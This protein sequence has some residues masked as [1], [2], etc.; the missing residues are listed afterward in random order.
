MKKTVV[1]TISA[2]MLFLVAAQANAQGGM[3]VFANIDTDD[4]SMLSDEELKTAGYN[5]LMA[6]M[7]ADEDGSVSLEEFNNRINNGG[8][9]QRPGG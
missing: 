7:D 1:T 2:A 3:P 6:R 5:G 4:N 8:G 9:G